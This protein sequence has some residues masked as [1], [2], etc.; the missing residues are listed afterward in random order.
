P[1]F[2]LYTFLL[3]LS[4]GPLLSL[5]RRCSLVSSLSLVRFS[6]LLSASSFLP[7]FP[8][9]FG[10]SFFCSLSFSPLLGP[11]IFSLPLP[12]CSPNFSPSHSPTSSL[13]SFPP[14]PL[15]LCL[16]SPLILSRSYTSLRSLLSSEKSPTRSFPPSTSPYCLLPSL[17]LLSPVLS[18]P[19]RV[20][21]DSLCHFSFFPPHLFPLS[22][23][24]LFSS[25]SPRV[26]LSLLFPPLPVPFLCSVLSALSRLRPTCPPPASLLF[27]LSLSLSV[28]LLF[29]QRF[30]P[31]LSPRHSLL[32]LSLLSGLRLSLSLVASLSLS[33]LGLS[34]SLSLSAS[35]SS[36]SRLP[37][38]LSVFSL[39][40]SG[41]L[42]LLLFSLLRSGF[43]SLFSPWHV[44]ILISLLFSLIL[45]CLSLSLLSLRFSLFSLSSGLSLFFLSRFISL[46]LSFSR[47]SLSLASLSLSPGFLSRSSLAYF[48]LLVSG[49]SLSLSR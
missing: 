24:S 42:S 26:L 21:H 9:S 37:S 35:L 23:V 22:R 33:L 15:P 25:F 46:S 2:S 6:L 16:L 7:R 36:F 4:L 32:S 5:F 40:L 41:F 12:P 8:S 31:L 10:R 34:L 20:H 14:A 44:G 43:L 11:F 3:L 49:F 30:S 29:F 38:L 47:G 45:P 13:P 27:S 39:S 18:L 19:I 17:L 28:P 48:S 1:N